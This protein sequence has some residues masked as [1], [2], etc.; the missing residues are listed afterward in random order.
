MNRWNFLGIAVLCLLA[1]C[2]GETLVKSSTITGTVLDIDNQPVRDATV[3]SRFGSTRTSPTGAYSLPKQA[4]G[5]IEIVA[6]TSRNGVTYR[7][8]TTAYTYVNEAT[9]SVNIVVG[10]ANELGAITGYVQDRNGYPLQDAAVYAYNGAGAS[11]RTFT[12]ENGDYALNDLV[13]GVSYTVL[14]GGQ[15]YRSDSSSVNL[16]VSDHQSLNFILDQPGLP[17]LQPPQNV[18]GTTWVSPADSTRGNDEARA[19]DAIKKMIDPRYKGRERAF[20][21]GSRAAN[22]ILVEADLYWD[23]Q[24]FPDLLGY[25]VYRANSANGVLDGFDFLPEPLAAYYVDLSLTQNSVFSY[26]FTTISAQYPD[27]PSQTESSPSTRVVART[28]SKLDISSPTFS[29]LTFRWNAGSGADW[30][31]VFLFDEFPGIGVNSIWNNYSNRVT[32]TSVVY[33]GNPLQTNH[34]YYYIVLGLANNDDSRT[35]SQ[36]GSFKL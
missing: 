36:I 8:R 32:G 19:Y 22:G 13:G 14:A 33:N 16:G 3:T 23:E 28:L 10:P 12:D 26:A 4:D 1:G 9:Q 27:N 20:G 17:N 25:G 2:G 18:A 35:I 15:G 7:G 31:A 30:Y 6:E 11:V 21:S 29:P 24:R 34:T 5:A